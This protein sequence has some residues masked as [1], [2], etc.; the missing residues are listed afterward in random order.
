MLIDWYNSGQ[1][2]STGRDAAGRGSSSGT[3]FNIDE[4]QLL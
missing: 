4:E 3:E 2:R 1:A